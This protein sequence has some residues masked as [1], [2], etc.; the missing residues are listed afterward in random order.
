[1]WKTK[2]RSLLEFFLENAV[3]LK[4][5]YGRGNHSRE[6]FV[7]PV[8]NVAVALK[9]KER[10]QRRLTLVAENKWAVEPLF[11]LSKMALYHKSHTKHTLFAKHHTV[12]RGAEALL[13]GLYANIRLHH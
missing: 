2:I 5:I 1:M 12:V 10:V 7:Y 3:T 6:I 11:N 4:E 8:A 9:L 13:V